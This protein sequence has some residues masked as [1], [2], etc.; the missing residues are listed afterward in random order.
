MEESEALAKV[1]AAADKATSAANERNETIRL[2][3]EVSS[4]R[5]VAAAAGLSSAR[6]HQ[7]AHHR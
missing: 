4:V 2:A 3:L 7:I 5:K 1:Q 6:V